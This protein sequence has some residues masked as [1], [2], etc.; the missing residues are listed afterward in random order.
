MITNLITEWSN[1]LNTV[2]GNN[3][4]LAAAV[5]TTL[6]FIAK[7]APSYILALINRQLFFSVRMTDAKSN[8]APNTY[9]SLL[10]WHRNSKW[11]RWSKTVQL[12]DSGADESE[13]IITGFGK[14]FFMYEGVI[15]W[16]FVSTKDLDNVEM[17]LLTVKTFIWNQSKL[18]RIL[19]EI[20]PVDYSLPAIYKVN[21]GNGYGRE[22]IV[23]VDRISRIYSTQR[24]L[25]DQHIYDQVDHVMDRMLNDHEWYVKTGRLHKEA[26]MLYGE[27]GTGKTNLIRHFASKYNLPILICR[28][29][30]DLREV[31]PQLTKSKVPNII[32]LE[33]ADSI[34]YIC[35]PE[36]ETASDGTKY[37]RMHA[38]AMNSGSAEVCMSDF[39]NYFDGVAP[40]SNSII[41]M[42]TNHIEKILPSVYRPGRIDH[43]INISYPKYETLVATL[44]WDVT[45]PRMVYLNSLTNHEI[46]LSTL[47]TLRAAETAAEVK[48]VMESRDD[49]FLLQKNAVEYTR[50]TDL[51]LEGKDKY[52]I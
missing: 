11:S 33:D 1:W 9:K 25:V 43:L 40:L 46:P 28:D 26:F 51:K 38:R 50:L 49:Y 47:V 31:Q 52:G 7:F 36:Y 27:P 19:L 29:V 39:L 2:T 16:M 14:H 42:T 12:R 41:F 6:L 22:V 45:D 5:F 37:R 24:Q 18:K 21:R 10:G 35:V 8:G 13:R 15:F 17:Q 3:H 34:D 32:L 48:E 20:H 44:G 4:F 30:G 23:E